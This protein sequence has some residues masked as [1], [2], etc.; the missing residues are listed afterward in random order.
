[1]TD[2]GVTQMVKY[3]SLSELNLSG[4]PVTD[5]AVAA[6]SECKSLTSLNLTRTKVTA[7]GVAELRKA[8]PACRV[9][10]DN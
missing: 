8:L 9:E 6:L 3:R 5:A 4:T 2:A 1:V 7:D 10:W